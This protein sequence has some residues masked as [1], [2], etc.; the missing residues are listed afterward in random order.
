MQG[1]MN[2]VIPT[3]SQMVKSSIASCVCLMARILNVN[4]LQGGPKKVSLIIFVITLSTASQ[5]S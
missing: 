5:F 3:V 4:G 2:R 1:R